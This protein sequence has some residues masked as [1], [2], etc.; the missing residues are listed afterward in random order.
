MKTKLED[1]I[2]LIFEKLKNY[3]YKEIYLFTFAR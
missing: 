1:S 2:D 3:K